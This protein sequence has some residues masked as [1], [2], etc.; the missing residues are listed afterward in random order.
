MNILQMQQ[1]SQRGVFDSKVTSNPLGLYVHIPYCRKRCNYCNFAIVPIGG[2]PERNTKFHEVD[3][4]YR[5]AILKELDMNTKYMH[6]AKLQT[7]Y[8]GGGTP[9][10]APIETI[11]KIMH[12]I[13]KAFAVE[14]NAEITIEMDPGR[15]VFL[16]ERGYMSYFCHFSA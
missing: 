12:A 4:L 5:L 14:K 1:Q 15:I 7:I 10:L 2:A 3:A 8:F 16:F 6:Q 9:S 11:Q 13:R